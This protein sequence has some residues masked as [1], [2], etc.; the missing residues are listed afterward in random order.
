[1]H[2]HLIAESVRKDNSS[3]ELI[4]YYADHANEPT[5]ALEVAKQEFAWRHD[6]YTLDAYA[7]AL[8]KN[9]EDAEAR[10]EIDQALAVGT[11]DPKILSHATEI[12]KQ[13]VHVASLSRP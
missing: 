10:K 8:H 9:G 13:P 4:F 3:R 11:K 1:M 5:K 6:V 12:N 7:W 2:R